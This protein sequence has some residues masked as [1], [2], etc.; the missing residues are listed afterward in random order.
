MKT[1]LLTIDLEEFD[2]PREFKIDIFDEEGI[3]WALH[4]NYSG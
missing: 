2:L 3:L 1:I 4:T